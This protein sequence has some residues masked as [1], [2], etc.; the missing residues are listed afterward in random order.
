MVKNLPENAGDTAYVG[1]IPRLGRSTG[2]GNDNPVLYSSLENPM[3][4]GAWRATI[5]VVAKVLDTT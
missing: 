3:D 4:R 1:L 2:E 5:H